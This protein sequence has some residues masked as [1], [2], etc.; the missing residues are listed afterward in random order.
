MALET[1]LTFQG[2]IVS[3]AYVRVGRFVFTSK[4]S[5]RAYWE[6]FASKDA[7]DERADDNQLEPFDGGIVDF[8]YSFSSEDSLHAQAYAALKL[9]P[10]FADSVDA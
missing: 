4:T 7:M 1:T 5:C 9:L 10:G 6:A 2:V 8:E 3:G